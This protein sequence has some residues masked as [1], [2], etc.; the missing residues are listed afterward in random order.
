MGGAGTLSG[1]WALGAGRTST[2]GC[3]ICQGPTKPGVNLCAQCKAALKRARQVTVSQLYPR[4]R[5]PSAHSGDRRIHKEARTQRR[6]EV[7]PASAPQWRF[8]VALM[9]A[10]GAVATGGY[11]ALYVARAGADPMASWTVAIPWLSSGSDAE[12]R[13]PPPRREPD[14]TIL[15]TSTPTPAVI[16]APRPFVLVVPAKGAS[17]RPLELPAAASAPAVARFAEAT[18]PP[19]PAPIAVPE[20][21]PAPA[22]PPDRWQ[23]MADGIALC[24][25]ENFIASVICEQRVRLQ[26]CEGYWGQAGQCPSGISNDHGR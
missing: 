12:S 16:E 6:V 2:K 15:L 22:P 19:E 21:V 26:Y 10:A 1:R 20:V 25:R 24:G 18:E 7:R 8:V 9:L 17:K 5:G 13:L 23:L 11:L 14:S 4:P 3:A